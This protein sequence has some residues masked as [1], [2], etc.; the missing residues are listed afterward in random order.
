MKIRISLLIMLMLFTAALQAAGF[1]RHNPVPGG[2]ALLP[3]GPG[4]QRPSV[5]FNNRPVIV[6]K[7]DGQWLAVLGL[8]LD[9][10]PGEHHLQ[11]QQGGAERSLAFQ[12]QSK[13]YP[14]QHITLSNQRQVSPSAE[15]LTRIRGELARSRAAY[16]K[17]SELE[18]QLG[19]MLPVDGRISGVF[20][21]RRFFNGQE[22]RPHS[23]LDIAAPTGTP[24]Q[25][26]AGGTVV[27]VGD[28]FFNGKTVF[29]DHGQG[30]VS[31][32]CHMDS[33]QV[34]PGQQLK[35]G[36]VIGTVGATGRV[37]GPHLHWSIS[38]NNTLIDPE[39]FLSE[40]TLAQLNAA[41]Q[42]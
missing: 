13:Q 1:P 41:N 9:S 37:T 24:I 35:Q 2:I 16:A 10:Q 39:L 4:E 28:F 3:L 25:A 33:I 6:T 15:D 29:I 20:G 7:R 11:W 27:E 14:E 8:P 26:P 32:Y 22:R 12:V 42:P 34:K 31:M 18:P 23:G 17:I 36:E 21:S 19:F 40:Q 5:R 30:L 38:M